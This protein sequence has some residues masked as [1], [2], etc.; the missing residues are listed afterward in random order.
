MKTASTINTRSI[1]E[2]VIRLGMAA[3]SC[4]REGSARRDDR[5]CILEIVPE[6]EDVDG[7]IQALE[8]TQ[9]VELVRARYL[10]MARS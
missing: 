5:S 7:V 6:P 8:P 1:L 9:V 10:A 2:A 4:W 3:F